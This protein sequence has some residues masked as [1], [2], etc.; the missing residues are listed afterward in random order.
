MKGQHAV[1]AR[2]VFSKRFVGR[3]AQYDELV[4]RFDDA[5][6]GDGAAVFVCG[7]AGIG[8][9]RLLDEFRHEVI[10]R[11]ALCATGLCLE[12]IQSPFAP[13]LQ[14][15][16]ALHAA[17]P[18]EL[19]S[20]ALRRRILA[21]LLP[22]LGEPQDRSEWLEEERRAQF[23]A[24]ASAF[25]S[26]AVRA[27]L[28]VIVEDLHWADTASLDLTQYL[29]GS[30][31]S[32][33]LLLL[34][35]CRID[36]LQK[37]NPVS[38]ALARFE[39]SKRFW[40]IHLDPLS[41]SD[42][43]SLITHALEGR[44]ILPPEAIHLICEQ[45]EGNPFFAEELLKNA[46]YQIEHNEA[47]TTLPQSIAQAVLE[48]VARMESNAHRVLSTAAAFGRRFNTPLLA[49]LSGLVVEDVLPT[50]KH[51][52]ELRLIVDAAAGDT[53]EYEY[54]HALIQ[55]TMYDELLPEQ[56]RTL[57]GRI[58]ARLEEAPHASSGVEDL[59]YHWWQAQNY[60][61][62]AHYNEIAGDT[63]SRL[64]A[65]G[66]AAVFYDRAIAA[67][68]K[69]GFARP[70][71]WTTF[72]RIL[73]CAGS[74]ERSRKAYQRALDHYEAQ[75]STEMIAET[76]VAYG[77]MCY[78]IG[79]YQTSRALLERARQV[80]EGSRRPAYFSAQVL[81]SWFYLHEADAGKAL[82]LLEQ[83]DRYK[84][85][86]SHQDEIR[87]YNYRA[88]ARQMLGEMRPSVEEF[89]RALNI[90]VETRDVLYQVRLRGNLA[91][92]LAS[93]G[94]RDAAEA[95]IREALRIAEE[96]CVQGYFL[97][98]CLAQFARISLDF[99]ALKRARDLIERVLALG[100]GAP[101]LQL[102]VA[103]HGMLVAL[104]LEDD[105]LLERCASYDMLENALAGGVR[106][107]ISS[108]AKGFVELYVARKE[109]QKAQT[110]LHRVVATFTSLPDEWLDEI[111]PYVAAYGLNDDIPRARAMLR[112]HADHVKN[113]EAQGQLCIFEGY[114]LRR[115]GDVDGSKRFGEQAAAIYREI[116]RPNFEALGLELAGRYEEALSL[117]R[118]IGNARDARRL[119]SVVSPPN[120]YGRAPRGL[121]RRELQVANLVADGKSNGAISA[122]LVI[123]ERTV[124]HHVASIFRKL[125]VSSRAELASRM[126]REAARTQ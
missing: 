99:G 4:R 19:T 56:A 79:D 98:C 76:C 87:F 43:N 15:L 45:A 75:G 18:A 10:K 39:R 6:R 67:T 86:R 94:Q 12:Y 83:A 52:R 68:E 115:A 50:I 29:I 27:P 126:A 57:H 53:G 44:D 122:A 102:D 104:Q 55:K 70:D 61:K 25:Q 90:A 116:R 121:T 11:Q 1:I 77:S 48:R 9:T 8:K 93:F 59:A 80:L 33:R 82:E 37:D 89:Q 32:S 21:R 105:D 41:H 35:S 28:V 114:A 74:G 22:E 97:A 51:A 110:L 125:E 46:I 16:R 31:G 78:N 113:L 23:E 69:L 42:V 63:A 96:R 91:L 13:Y 60:E 95:S 65:F 117:Y 111:L 107:Q 119:E 34:A 85:E 64:Y 3:R 72:G 103:A 14:I 112:R 17:V 106:R 36:E 100:V 20:N 26:F 47:D 71:L 49:E 30:L 84:G 54:R 7:E 123:S 38:G 81:L 2:P 58:A 40:E 62:A 73:L 5:A 101:E 109:V 92:C 24:I 124:E 108:I 120:R 66:D 88:I 118:Q